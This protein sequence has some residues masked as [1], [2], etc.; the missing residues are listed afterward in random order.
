MQLQWGIECM[1]AACFTLCIAAH[2][3]PIAALGPG[4]LWDRACVGGVRPGGRE[5][6]T[7][8]LGEEGTWDMEEG[9]GV[10]WLE[11]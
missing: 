2:C 8:A 3:M 7:W 1:L 10:G 11:V 5:K 6:G 9:W 4:L